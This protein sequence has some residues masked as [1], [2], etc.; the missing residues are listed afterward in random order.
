MGK[1]TDTLILKKSYYSAFRNK[2]TQ[3]Q[4]GNLLDAIYCYYLGE[5]YKPFLEDVAVDMVFSFIR[6]FAELCQRNYEDKSQRNSANAKARWENVQDDAKNANASERIRTQ[7]TDAKL[8]LTNTNTITNTKTNTGILSLEKKESKKESGQAATPK[9]FVKPSIEDVA[10]YAA[11]LHYIGFQV[12]KFYAHYEA[13]GWM[14]GKTKMV[15]WKAA[16]R[17]WNSQEKEMRPYKPVDNIHNI[18]DFSNER[19]R[20]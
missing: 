8:C 6:E 9:R 16:V 5:D 7:P 18:G 14:V 10:A 15:D 11:S 12:Q 20:I 4:K 13:N 2:L 19:T 17:Y 1:N 3:E